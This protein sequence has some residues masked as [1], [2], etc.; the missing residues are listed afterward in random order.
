MSW[1]TPKNPN[2]KGFTPVEFQVLDFSKIDLK[3]FFG[4]LKLD[5]S[6]INN[7]LE[8]LNRHQENAGWRDNMQEQVDEDNA[9]RM[10]DAERVRGAN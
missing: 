4:D 7:Q 9:E 8:E 1:G 3:D 6:R 10:E 5:A 2:C